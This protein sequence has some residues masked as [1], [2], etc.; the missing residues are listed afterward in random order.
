MHN[1]TEVK[2]KFRFLSPDFEVLIERN[3]H[4]LGAFRTTPTLAKIHFPLRR[5]RVVDFE[6]KS[7]FLRKTAQEFST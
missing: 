2:L 7:R 1:K 5:H 3:L 6:F 4:L